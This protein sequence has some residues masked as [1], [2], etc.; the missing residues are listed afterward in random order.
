MGPSE[1]YFTDMHGTS[2]LNLLKKLERLV[3][4][5][6]FEKIDFNRKMT[7]IRSTSVSPEILHISGPTL[8]QGWHQW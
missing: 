7:A 6:G 2:S 1:V 5:A 3:M 8:R 4:A